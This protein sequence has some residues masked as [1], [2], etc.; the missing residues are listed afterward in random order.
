MTL[1]EKNEQELNKPSTI[2]RIFIGELIGHFVI[3]KK[4]N[5]F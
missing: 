3:F 4:I 2:I 5:F 1:G